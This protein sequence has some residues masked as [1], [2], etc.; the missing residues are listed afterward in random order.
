M[1]RADAVR[2]YPGFPWLSLDDLGSVESFL[3]SRGWITAGEHVCQ[4]EKPGDG[5]M[6]LTMRVTT[7]QRTLIVKQAR[8][9]VEKY[10]HISAPWDRIQ[11]ECRF[12]ERIASIPSVAAR[13]PQLLGTD[14]GARVLALEDLVDARS[15]AS[16]YSGE[17]LTDDEIQ[18]LA[19]Y[20]SSLHEATR[21][22]ADP[23]F[24]NREMR[25]LNHQHVFEIPLAE[26]NG[27]DLEHLEHGLS[28]AAAHL[29]NDATYRGLVRYVGD[30]YLSAGPVLVHGDYFPG[31]WLRTGKGVFVIDPEFCFYGDPEFDLGGTIAH[32]R[33]AQQPR[34]HARAFLRTYSEHSGRI[35]IQSSLLTSFAAVEVMRR[36]IGVAQLPL[37]VSGAQRAHLLDQSRR[38]MINQSWEELWD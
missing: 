18:Q 27:I 1:N 13:M 32:F 9:W 11:Y 4:C 26:K 6:N 36:L 28:V 2:Q 37:P 3:R 14:M 17:L 25:Q 33:L 31:S 34:E 20:L 19:G 21:G 16:L 24:E 8:P 38:A 29:Q 5:N 23:G 30:R 15:L 10:D 12:Y 22:P 35:A 7:E